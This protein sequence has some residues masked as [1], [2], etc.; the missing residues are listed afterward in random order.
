MRRRPIPAW[1]V[2]RN[3]AREAERNDAFNAR[4][5]LLVGALFVDI[6]WSNDTLRAYHPR[7]RAFIPRGDHGTVDMAVDVEDERYQAC[8]HC[9][10]AL[11]EDDRR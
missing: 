4:L 3:R 2:R 5:G 9:G 7:C 10:G 11:H 6:V 1:A 8:A